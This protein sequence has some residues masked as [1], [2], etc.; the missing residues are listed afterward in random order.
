MAERQRRLLH[1]RSLNHAVRTVTTRRF[2]NGNA[3]IFALKFQLA[4]HAHLLGS[5]AITANH[6]RPLDSRLI[7]QANPTRRVRRAPHQT[8]ASLS[9]FKKT[10]SVYR[11]TSFCP[12]RCCRGS[13]PKLNNKTTIPA[14]L[15]APCVPSEKIREIP[16]FCGMRQAGTQNRCYFFSSLI[17]ISPLVWLQRTCPAPRMS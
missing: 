7:L 8:S 13:P 1:E 15:Q 4:P 11:G 2:S 17:K 16:V 9:V 3:D 6:L 10:D 12:I 5:T 14:H